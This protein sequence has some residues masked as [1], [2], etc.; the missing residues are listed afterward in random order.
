MRARGPGAGPTLAVFAWLGPALWAAGESP[1]GGA[2]RGGPAPSL[3]QP[4]VFGDSAEMLRAKAGAM[5]EPEDIGGPNPSARF[6]PSPHLPGALPLKRRV[7]TC[8]LLTQPG[9]CQGGFVVHAAE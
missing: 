5:G 1:G 2:P 4:G 8:L 9:G 3:R 7:L 6:A